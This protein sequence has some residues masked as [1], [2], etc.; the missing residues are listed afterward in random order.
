VVVQDKALEIQ[1]DMVQRVDDA[2][3]PAEMDEA[4]VLVEV[5]L[6]VD[7]VDMPDRPMAAC[8]VKR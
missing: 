2:V 8:V 5:D 7:Q 6:K 4:T 3:L 1:P